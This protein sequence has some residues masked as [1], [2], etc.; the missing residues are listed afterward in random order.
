MRG[1]AGEAMSL[2]RDRGPLSR[3]ELAR[4]I[5]VSAPALTNLANSLLGRG[6]VVETASSAGNGIGRPASLLAL[7]PDNAFALGIHFGVGRVGVVLAD[8]V[9]GVKARDNHLLERDGTS[10]EEAMALAV[11]AANALIESAGVPRG[12]IRG[13]GVGVPGRVDASG[14]SSL[15]AFFSHSAEGFPFADLL[16]EQLGLPVRLSH[17]VTAMALAEALYGAGRGAASVLNLYMRRGLGAG[18]VQR[19]AQGA[20]R[21]AAVELGHISV[22]QGS[23]RHCHCGNAGCLETV[24]SERALLEQMAC[25]SL[26]AGGLFQAAMADAALWERVYPAFVQVLATAVT[27]LEPELI[28]LSGHLGEA[29]PRLLDSLR[30]DLPPRVMPQ[31]RGIRIER[32]VLQPDA[33]ALGAACIGL[34]HFVYQG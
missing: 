1:S 33:G 2:L 18:L 30:T 9:L 24:F 26:P 34:E 29:P 12:R 23:G 10:V 14:R 31:F 28:L 32:A 3:A 22:G 17:N 8:A 19:S 5:G 11:S 7:V 21:S 15:N 27:L 13:I 4:S 16:E 25:R 6:S 20:I